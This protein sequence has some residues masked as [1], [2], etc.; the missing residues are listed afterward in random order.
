MLE[1]LTGAGLAT[2]SGL[3]AFIPMLAL[4]LLSRFTDLVTLPTG[5]EWLE[6][7][8]VL[9]ILGVLLVFELVADKIPAFDTVNDWIQTVIRPTSG[10]IVFG[11]GTAAVTVAIT[12]PAEWWSTNAWVPVVIG[13]VTA[14]VV[15]LVKAG[16]RA[17][18]NAVSAGTAAPVMSVGEDAVSVGLVFSAILVPLFVLV[19]LIVLGLLVWSMFRSYRRIRDRRQAKVT[20]DS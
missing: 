2:A 13:V 12:D 9:G 8:W 15:H 16:T 10:G 14:L 5:W 11:A 19:I 20:A 3:N 6:N 7:P 1:L 4:G 18:A 17:A